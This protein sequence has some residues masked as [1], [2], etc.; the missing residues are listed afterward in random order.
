M[1][2][3]ASLVPGS[4]ALFL[5]W[6]DDNER[7][8]VTA[9]IKCMVKKLVKVETIYL[10]SILCIRNRQIFEDWP[11]VSTTMKVVLCNK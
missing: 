8:N 7:L 10:G 4:L 5:K 11:S 9:M 3:E 1:D 2:V 6:I